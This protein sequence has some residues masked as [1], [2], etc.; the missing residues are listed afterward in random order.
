MS[1]T[2]HDAFSIVELAGSLYCAGDTVGTVHPKS[3]IARRDNSPLPVT[4][5]SFLL[6]LH[7]GIVM[8][9]THT[10]RST[11]RD[12]SPSTRQSFRACSK[13]RYRAFLHETMFSV[14]SSQSMSYSKLRPTRRLAGNVSIPIWSCLTS[15]ASYPAMAPTL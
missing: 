4:I 1:L 11:S 7:L 2:Q 9:S 3:P 15:R 10:L 8:S 5:V 6:P 13:P 12:Y 14:K